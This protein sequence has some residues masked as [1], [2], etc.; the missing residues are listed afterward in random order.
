VLD[1]TT[2]LTIPPE[3][4]TLK[5]YCASLAHKVSIQS[6]SI[7]RPIV[8]KVTVSSLLCNVTCYSIAELLHLKIR[9]RVSRN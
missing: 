3:M 1:E 9:Y 5:D 6:V 8:G 2:D 4:T 7:Q